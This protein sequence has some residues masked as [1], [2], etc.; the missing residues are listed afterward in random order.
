MSDKLAVG[1]SRGW[2]GC[3]RVDMEVGVWGCKMSDIWGA[4]GLMPDKLGVAVWG[5]FPSVEMSDISYLLNY[6]R[7]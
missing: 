7:W 5:S 4:L 2:L 3:A 1:I 6:G